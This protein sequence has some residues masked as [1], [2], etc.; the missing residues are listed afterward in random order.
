MSD[1]EGWG[2]GNRAGDKGFDS[3][4]LGEAD[5]PHRVVCDLIF[6]EHPHSRS[7]NTFYARFPDGRIEAFDGH[8]V[9]VRFDV[10]ES[11]Y[12]KTSGLSGNEIRK[13]CTG[14]LYFNDEQVYTAHHRTWE[15]VMRIL[16]RVIPELLE[17]NVQIWKTEERKKLIGMKVYYKDTPATIRSY[18]Q[19]FGEIVLE[20]ESDLFPIPAYRREDG[21]EDDPLEQRVKTSLLDPNIWWWRK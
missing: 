8:R 1:S 13:Q 4:T 18:D 15:G 21:R 16:N 9:R 14:K 17:H 19:E 2:V 5:Y 7:D 3:I 10:E 11:N 20:A 12:L 6:G